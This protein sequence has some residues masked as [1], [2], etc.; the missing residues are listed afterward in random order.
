VH[1]SDP[2]D[3]FLAEVFLDFMAPKRN[4][5]SPATAPGVAGI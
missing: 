3:L 4:P 2:R 1:D 5:G